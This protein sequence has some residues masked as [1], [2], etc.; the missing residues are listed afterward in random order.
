MRKSRPFLI[1]GTY[2]LFSSYLRLKT[3]STVV[4][5]EVG[6]LD[7]CFFTLESLT[8]LSFVHSHTQY[9]CIYK[10]HT[11]VRLYAGVYF[12]YITYSCYYLWRLC[13]IAGLL[14]IPQYI[15]VCM[16]LN[17]RHHHTVLQRQGKATQMQ[18]NNEQQRRAWAPSKI[19][20][21]LWSVLSLSPSL[22]TMYTH[23]YPQ[24]STLIDSDAA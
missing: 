18:Q 4:E 17:P 13:L 22:F 7:I 2:L 23:T 20:V 15:Y 3:P 21:W 9:R 10:L 19:H 14:A 16:F 12:N 11:C 5:L 1:T 24:N 6:T 8:P